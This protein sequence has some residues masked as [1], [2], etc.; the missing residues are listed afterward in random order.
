MILGVDVSRYQPAVDWTLLKASGV[1]FVFIKATQ[2]NYYR[3]PMLDQHVAGAHAA[4]L[5]VGLYHWCDPLSGDLAQAQY[6]LDKT[7]NLPY[8][9]AVAD[10][11]Q[12]WAD[13]TEWSAG[14]ITRILPPAQIAS[15]ARNCLAHWT[16]R[17]RRAL[18]YS[19]AS[20]IRSYA[21]PMLP[22]INDY[23]LW[24]AHYPYATGRVAAT[25]DDIR[26]KY[27]PSI[28]GPSLPDGAKTWR[29]WQFSGDKFLL[30]GI[31]ADENRRRLSPTDLN[32][33]NGTLAELRAFFGVTDAPAPVEA[34]TLAERVTALET[35]AR[36]K[37]WQ[38]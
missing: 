2:G 21:R 6:F 31:F 5:L 29:F 24:L 9:V 28:P 15:T 16:L 36:A 18:L 19:R 20:F 3:D 17:G 1:E 37:G 26:G 12:Q 13:W 33:F 32:F 14:K 22:W 38:V 23:P 35:E 4:G 27:A 8:Y 25:W 30:P 10:V 34:K 11:E 7:A